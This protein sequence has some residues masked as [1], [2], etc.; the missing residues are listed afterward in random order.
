[1][2]SK[3]RKRIQKKLAQRN[4]RH[5]QQHLDVVRKARLC[6]D[7]VKEMPAA[8]RSVCR[9]FEAWERAENG[10]SP[11]PVRLG[12]QPEPILHALMAEGWA[13]LACPDELE[14]PGIRRAA[15]AL[16]KQLMRRH[17]T[18]LGGPEF[19]RWIRDEILR[20]LGDLS[21]Q[22]ASP[23]AYFTASYLEW[24][25]RELESATM[26]RQ[27][28]EYWPLPSPDRDCTLVEAMT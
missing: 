27:V 10:E 13:A 5:D 3:T 26:R 28:N 15:K 25:C 16:R 19:Y 11:I 2:H 7:T 1:M 24:L 17:L 23:R 21:D 12:N 20:L 22:H 18:R 14:T 4:P 8:W 6:Y 9:S